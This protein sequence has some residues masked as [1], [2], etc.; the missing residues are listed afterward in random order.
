MCHTH[1]VDRSAAYGIFPYFNQN[2]SEQVS[3]GGDLCFRRLDPALGWNLPSR[4]PVW[5]PGAGALGWVPLMQTAEVSPPRTPTLGLASI[6]PAVLTAPD[7]PAP[8]AHRL[9]P[10]ESWE[11]R[12]LE[13]GSRTGNAST[14][15]TV[16]QHQGD[17]P[18]SAGLLSGTRT[19]ARR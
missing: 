7:A 11:N 10:R 3:V 13:W 14:P 4:S 16:R 9:T 6:Y 19:G 15:A 17:P 1:T 12:K 8:G 2:N 18:H 5:R